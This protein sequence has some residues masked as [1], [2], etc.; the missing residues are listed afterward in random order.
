MSCSAT[1]SSRRTLLIG[2]GLGGH[3]K[4][5]EGDP[6]PLRDRP[7]VLVVRH[8]ERDLHRE[9]AVAVSVE[10][11][12][13]AVVLPGHHEERPAARLLASHAED[14]IEA[15]GALE[16]SGADRLRL[17]LR[18]LEAGAHREQSGVLVGEL[19]LLEHVGPEVEQGARDGV[20]DAGPVLAAQG[21][22]VVLHAPWSQVTPGAAGRLSSRRCTRRAPTASLTRV[23]GSSTSASYRS[24]SSR[25]SAVKT[26]MNL[27]DRCCA[28]RGR[29]RGRRGPP[30]ATWAALAVL[31]SVYDQP[32]TG[33]GAVESCS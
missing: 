24:T 12:D 9:L 17:V 15:G 20:D 22:D 32:S 10:Q 14:R 21:E 33:W 13:E 19:R 11:V 2:L 3:R 5:D 25:L 16:H 31:A 26:S 1:R 27:G 28:V 6:V 30:A 8:H 4:D 23:L 18:R 29:R 7:A